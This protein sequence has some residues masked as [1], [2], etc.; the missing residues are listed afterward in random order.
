MPAF[1]PEK[2]IT[3]V[4]RASQSQ[5]LTV[6]A[7]PVG[8]DIDIGA[9]GMLITLPVGSEVAFKY[10]EGMSGIWMTF[11]VNATNHSGTTWKVT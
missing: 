4:L 11:A 1:R 8:A 2:S 5:V 6:A 3:A 9:T 10:L 7:L